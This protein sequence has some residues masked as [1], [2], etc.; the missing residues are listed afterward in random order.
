MAVYSK[1][2]WFW[3][4]VRE[5]RP[6]YSRAALASLLSNI[7][8]FAASIYSMVIFDKVI[9][10][11]SM[12][13]LFVL[14]SGVILILA[15][16]Y[17]IR[18]VRTYLFD[19]AGKHIDQSVANIVFEKII[20]AN[21]SQPR[22]DG[23]VA[24]AIKDFDVL[25][26]FISSATIATFVD[27]PF[28]VLFVFALFY[29]TGWLCLVPVVSIIVL[30]LTGYIAHTRMKSFSQEMQA[31]SQSKQATI[32]EALQNKDLIC[33][34]DAGG[35]FKGRWERAIELQAESQNRSKDISSGA[36][37]FVQLIGQLN[38]IVVLS[39]GAALAFQ[40]IIGIGALVA[41][42]I[43]A[44]R[45][46]APFS[47]VV[48]LLSRLSQVMQSYRALDAM[49]SESD[50][51]TAAMSPVNIDILELKPVLQLKQ[52]SLQYP[53]AKQPVLMNLNLELSL[54]MVVVVL[55]KSGAGKSTML[56][57]I[58]GLT[59]P[60]AGDVLIDGVNLKSFSQEVRNKRFSIA[61]QDPMIFSGTLLENITL[62]TETPDSKRLMQVI[63]V[64]C[65][66]DL[67]G[68]LSDGLASKVRERGQDFSGGQ[69]QLISIARALYR[70]VD[71]YFFDEPTSSLDPA[72]EAK[73]IHNLQVFLGN[74]A[75]LFS[76]HK[77]KP[78]DI[79]THCLVLESG[80]VAYF[81]QTSVVLA[82]LNQASTK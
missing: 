33:A 63:S 59:P 27:I 50:Q 82:R 61:M 66:E 7:F 67:I 73:L 64:C 74:K 76:T 1:I 15:V 30:V 39:L 6:L 75:V 49:I 25:K 3:G 47:Q 23:A 32:I 35:L 36:M 79:S 54:G 68:T 42:S 69:R 19:A 46:I 77:P 11:Q 45:A 48:S 62:S 80:R 24:A 55:G 78:L 17:G 38:Q 31:E 9:P 58:S 57:L 37:N 10:S 72:T 40:N 41:A 71:F 44:S 43:M 8:A 18:N 12:S 51:R 34:M 5:L 53:N 26:E 2:H 70:D 22:R 52:L 56:R 65:L 29:L 81:D 4:A 28:A 16:D 60:S 21:S 13:S 20:L 14:F